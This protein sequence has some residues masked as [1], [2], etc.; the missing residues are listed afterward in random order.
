M[1]KNWSSDILY[2]ISNLFHFWNSLLRLLVEIIDWFNWKNYIWR[3]YFII[4]IVSKMSANQKRVWPELVGKDV[5]S[6]LK[7]LKE[8]SG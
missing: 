2:F 3:F 1:K 8:E 5:N 4:T 7:T 6:A